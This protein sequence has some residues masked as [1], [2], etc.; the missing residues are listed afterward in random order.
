LSASDG[1]EYHSPLFLKQALDELAA[2]QRDLA[3]KVKFSNNWHK[4]RRK[5]THIY[6]KVVNCRRD[7][8]FKLAHDLT[9]RYDYL[10]FEDLAM[11]GMQALWGRKIGDLARSE[12]MGILEYIAKIKGKFVDYVDRFYPSSK[13]CSDCGHVNKELT[14]S[15]RR[16][17]C[18]GCGIIHD[19]DHN[20]AINIEREGASSLNLGAVRPAMLA[21]T[22]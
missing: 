1:T 22:A 20:A 2:A 18:T 3:R 9:D 14:L 16:W 13:T 19:R 15:D 5:V 7:W 21:R 12:F 6:Q 4:A 10:H 11:K 8:F 17:A